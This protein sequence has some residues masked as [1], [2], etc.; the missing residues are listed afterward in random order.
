[1]EWLGQ[2]D[3][4]KDGLSDRFVWSVASDDQANLWIGAEHRRIEQLQANG[5]VGLVGSTR[6]LPDPSVYNLYRTSTGVCLSAPAPASRAGTAPG[7]SAIRSGNPWRSPASGRLWITPTRY[8]IGTSQLP[9]RRELCVHT[10]W[11]KV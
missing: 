8:W 6:A 7:W 2:P 9:G 1:M 3:R 5:A 10:G 11:N 4:V